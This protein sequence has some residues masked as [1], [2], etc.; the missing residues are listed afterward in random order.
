MGWSF[1][2]CA[3]EL[4]SVGTNI[5]HCGGATSMLHNTGL[6]FMQERQRE[7]ARTEQDLRNQFL[8]SSI[9]K[10]IV[11]QSQSMRQDQSVNISGR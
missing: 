1:S 3:R 5:C 4:N 10:G 11:N 8:Q 2:L 9:L 6:Y 7:N